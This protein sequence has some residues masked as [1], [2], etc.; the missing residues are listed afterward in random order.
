MNYKQFLSKNIKSLKQ[1]DY[2][3]L[4]F[5]LNVKYDKT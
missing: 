4:N 1:V 2:D 3:Y 5:N